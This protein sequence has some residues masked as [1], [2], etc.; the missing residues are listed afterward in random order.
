MMAKRLKDYLTANSILYNLYYYQFDFRQNYS[1]ILALIYVVDDIYSHLENNEYV[2]SI[3]LD[4]QKGFDTVDHS[5]LL[6]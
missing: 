3:Y 1:T 6:W 4:L 5:I 2:L